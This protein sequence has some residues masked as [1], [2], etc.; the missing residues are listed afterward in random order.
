[1][2]RIIKFQHLSIALGS[3][4]EHNSDVLYARSMRKSVDLE[5]ST[6]NVDLVRN[7]KEVYSTG[8]LLVCRS[9]DL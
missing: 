7:R 5:I 9:I 1:M 8:V 3:R 6:L 4:E 2:V